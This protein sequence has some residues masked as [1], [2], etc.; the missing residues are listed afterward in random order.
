MDKHTSIVC[1]KISFDCL[2]L[3]THPQKNQNASANHSQ[4]IFFMQVSYILHATYCILLQLFDTS[5][6]NYLQFYQ[7]FFSCV[8][9]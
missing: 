6:V 5:H 7:L 9:S 2:L 3:N 4:G 8:Q 1:D